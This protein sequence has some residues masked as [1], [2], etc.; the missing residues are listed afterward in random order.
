MGDKSSS[1]PAAVAVDDNVLTSEEEAAVRDLRT[2]IEES[3][4][5]GIDV[6]AKYTNFELAKFIIVAKCNVEKA[7]KRFK[8]F[9]KLRLKHKFDE[10]SEEDV[11]KSARKAGAFIGLGGRDKQGRAIVC[12]DTVSCFFL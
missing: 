6:A 11:L 5:R 1:P 3:K 2:R 4:K 8:N 12:M 9:H 10:L 7:Y